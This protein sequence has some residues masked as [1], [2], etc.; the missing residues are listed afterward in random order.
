MSININPVDLTQ[1]KKSTVSADYYG[2]APVTG[3][4]QSLQPKI[5][6][7]GNLPNQTSGIG[8]GGQ[9]VFNVPV[10]TA[11]I[12]VA[13]IQQKPSM[14][15]PYA[16]ANPVSTQRA[17]QPQMVQP[18]DGQVNVGTAQNPMWQAYGAVAPQ[19]VPKTVDDIQK[20]VALSFAQTADEQ[21]ASDLEKSVSDYYKSQFNTVVDRDAEYKNSLS[22]YQAQ[23]D[24]I[25][26]IYN[27]QLTQSRIRNAPTYAGRIESRKFAQGRAGQIGS[28]TGEAGINAVENANM[29]EQAAAEALIMD[30]RE[31]AIANI[32][33]Q[34]R[35]SSEKELE[36][37]RL[38]K[39]QG[40][41][42]LVKNLAETATNRKKKVNNA[43]KALINQGYSVDDLS[44]EQ[45][46]E[47]AK[48]GLTSDMLKTEY[49]TEKAAYDKAASEEKAKQAKLEAETAQTVRETELLGKMNDYQ[50]AQLEQD[51]SQFGMTYALDKAKAEMKAAEDS[52]TNVQVAQTI[53]K[54]M[55]T[56]EWNNRPPSMSKKAFKEKQKEYIYSVG[57][58][59]A[60][61]GY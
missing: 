35:Q 30:K 45:L 43:V 60:D 10:K 58:N 46:D 37:K 47:L 25:N 9:S 61:F 5:P 17:V 4:I 15:G 36:A 27:D 49:A 54:Q 8:T 6:T 57:G 3:S 26:N 41:E 50:K 13:P 32:M 7:I 20:N 40:A 1:K 16:P 2:S 44:K 42:A 51:A 11:P 53:Y 38:A 34:V 52:M 59:P 24:A 14:N 55:A 48:Q 33:G 19:P 21:A 28:G 56:P 23:I 18:R 39:S 12:Q 31:T 29:E 22:M